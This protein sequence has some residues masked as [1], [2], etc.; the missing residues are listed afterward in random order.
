MAD[1]VLGHGPL[2]KAKPKYRVVRPRKALTVDMLTAKRRQAAQDARDGI[3]L[4]TE[5]EQKAIHAA[6]LKPIPQGANLRVAGPNVPTGW[7]KRADGSI[8]EIKYPFGV[9]KV[10][11]PRRKVIE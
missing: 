10:G 7:R 5:R 3:E 4:Y 6:F 11:N 1:T 8:K 9:Q 2:P